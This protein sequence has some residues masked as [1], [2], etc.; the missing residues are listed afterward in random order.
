M[1]GRDLIVGALLHRRGFDSRERRRDG[2]I[3]HHPCRRAPDWG[4]A[5]RLR[6]MYRAVRRTRHEGPEDLGGARHGRPSGLLTAGQ[7]VIGKRA[8]EIGEIEGSTPAH[9]R[10]VEAS[11]EVGRGIRLAAVGVD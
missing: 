4:D 10:Q 8:G 9:Q 2:W 1:G 6:R 11:G 7:C 5:G 3:R